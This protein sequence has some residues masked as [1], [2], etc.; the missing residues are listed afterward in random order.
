[1]FVTR[2]TPQGDCLSPSIF[3]L[4]INLCLRHLRSLGVGFNH[5]CGISRSHTAFADDIALLTNTQREMNILLQGV[6]DFSQWSGMDLCLVKC[7][8]SGVDFG[9]GKSFTEGELEIVYGDG[10]V[11][12]LDAAT[13]F[14][15]LGVRLALTGST[16]SEVDYVL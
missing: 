10:K 5:E 16:Q 15:Y 8:V 7:E 4:F 11:P 6:K 12:F 2:G 1:M 14:K 9:T 3:N 13:A